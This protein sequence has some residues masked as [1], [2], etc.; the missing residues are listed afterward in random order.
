MFHANI[1]MLK[2]MQQGTYQYIRGNLKPKKC[3]LYLAKK[4]KVSKIFSQIMCKFHFFSKNQFN[5]KS[6]SKSKVDKR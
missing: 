6:Y 1:M 5:S 2:P 4:E 3:R